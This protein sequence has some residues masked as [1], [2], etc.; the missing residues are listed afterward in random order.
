MK[1]VRIILIILIFFILIIHVQVMGE[2]WSVYPAFEDHVHG[3][4]SLVNMQSFALDSKLKARVVGED[5]VPAGI[6]YMIS[7]TPINGTDRAVGTVMTD[8][9]GSVLE[10]RGTNQDPSAT[11]EW[12]DKSMVSG[13]IV[14]F[15][16]TFTYTS[17]I[18]L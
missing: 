4:V 9:A 7:V 3:S 18:Q 10:A 16:K 2:S 5:G 15:M 13:S 8:F 17:G 12:R 11:N 14:N 1:Q 6:D